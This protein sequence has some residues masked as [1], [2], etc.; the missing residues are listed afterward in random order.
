MC[1]MFVCLTW[2]DNTYHLMESRTGYMTFT[3]TS[4][5][6]QTVVRIWTR[7]KDM[8]I[9]STLLT[10]DDDDFWQTGITI[11]PDKN[12]NDDEK[13]HYAAA[14]VATADDVY[15]SASVA[16]AMMM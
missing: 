12:D 6:H 9:Y 5:Y 14:S 7:K 10:H 2:F 15:V 3:H 4:R 16:A 8:F 11:G 13:I 1:Y